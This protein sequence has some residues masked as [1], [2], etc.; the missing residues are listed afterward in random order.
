MEKQVL[1]CSRAP[2]QTR[3][4][5]LL[6]KPEAA[7]GEKREPTFTK[8]HIGMQLAVTQSAR[9]QQR[10]STRTRNRRRPNADPFR[11]LQAERRSSR[12]GLARMRPIGVDPDIG[13]TQRNRLCVC[14]K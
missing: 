11:K 13:I 2:R 5:A 9:A 6:E 12:S 10:Q 1:V 14:G 7:V 3:G 8:V 4:T